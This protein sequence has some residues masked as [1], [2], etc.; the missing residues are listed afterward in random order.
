MEDPNKQLKI[1][2][3][4]IIFIIGML[5]WS[6]LTQAQSY[7]SLPRCDNSVK[8]NKGFN[9]CIDPNWDLSIKDLED[10]L[11]YYMIK[12]IRFDRVPGVMKCLNVYDSRGIF[13]E[14]CNEPGNNKIVFRSDKFE[15]FEMWEEYVA[16][17]EDNWMYSEST[18]T[19]WLYNVIEAGFSNPEE[20]L[21]IFY[22]NREHM[23]D[24]DFEVFPENDM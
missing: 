10:G 15:T 14:Y 21:K 12:K 3:I 17:I 19:Y 7:E 6:N 20:H 2:S 24:K 8:V 13:M 22:M 4:L 23:L 11:D 5:L 18:G 1:I 9:L 16:Y